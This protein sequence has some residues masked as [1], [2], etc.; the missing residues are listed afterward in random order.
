MLSLSLSKSLD[1][2]S[3]IKGKRGAI[4]FTSSIFLLSLPSYFNECVAQQSH[5]EE[6][7]AMGL[8]RLRRDKFW[9]LNNA[10]K[11]RNNCRKS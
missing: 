7:E 2:R 11:S 10:G 9:L 4:R 1:I 8:A 6:A 5:F 3:V